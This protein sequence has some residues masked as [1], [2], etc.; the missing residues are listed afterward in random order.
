MSEVFKNLLYIILVG[1]HLT[2]LFRQLYINV[3]CCKGASFVHCNKKIPVP[4]LLYTGAKSQ[5][6]YVVHR[7]V[8]YLR[9]VTL[10][11]VYCNYSFE[12][13][14]AKIILI[15]GSK[16]SEYEV[17]SPTKSLNSFGV[18]GPG[19]VVWIYLIHSKILLFSKQE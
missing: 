10:Q 14:V 5:C 3:R 4:R 19:W 13:S 15:Y 2:I 18:C 16:F 11:L 9:L 7:R 12:D 1:W 6:T 17:I 8:S